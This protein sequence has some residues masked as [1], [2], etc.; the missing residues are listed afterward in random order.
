MFE[1]AAAR[2]LGLVSIGIGLTEIA[3]PKQLERVMGIGNGQN[4]GIFRVLGVREIM[5]GV[6]ILSHSDPTPGVWS[7]VAGDLLDGVLL[8][9]AAKRTRN[10][11]GFAAICAA[12]LPVVLLDM[13][14]A[15]RLSQKKQQRSW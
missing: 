8:G 13:I 2:G 5:H 11:S 7:R 14:V 1:Q 15:P 3:A 6:D 9:L 10:P 12:V 4:T